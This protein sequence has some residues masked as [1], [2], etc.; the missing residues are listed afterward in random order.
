MKKTL[1]LLFV[2][3]F[4]LAAALSAAALTELPSVRQDASTYFKSPYT[5]MVGVADPFILYDEATATYYLYSTGGH[6]LCYRSQTL[7]VWE[8]LDD[9][10]AVTDKTFGTEKYW[11]PEVYK[12]GDAFYM[13]YSAARDVGGVTRHSIGVATSQSPA[14]PFTDLYDHPLYDPGYNVIDASLLFD[15][16][17]IY[18]YYSRDCSENLIDGKKVS[19]VC[20]IEVKSDLS[21]IVGEPAVLTTP[22]EPWETKTGSTL[23]NEGPCVLK[24][25][26]VYYLM[27]SANYFGSASY[28]V[29]YATASSPL[30]PYKKA[31]ENPILEGDGKATAGTGH[32]NYFRSPDGSELYLVYHSRANIAEP[33]KGSRMLCIDRLVITGDGRLRI[34]GPSSSMQPIPSGVNGLYK[35]TDGIS[36]GSTYPD[37]L[38]HVTNLCDDLV[39]YGR[40]DSAS[41]YRFVC[42]DDGAITLRYD[43]PVSLQAIWLYGISYPTLCPQSVYAVADG[44]YRTQTKM[45]S[46]VTAMLPVALLFD[47]MPE[48]TAVREV[49]L[50]FTPQDQNGRYAALSEIITVTRGDASTGGVNGVSLGQARNG[51]A[52]VRTYRGG[53]TDVA[54]G[55]W[56]ADYI[57]AA[58]EYGLV[59]GTTATTFSPGD[60]FTVAAALTAA[61]NIR[62]AYTGVPV[63]APQSGDAWYM[64]YLR[65]CIENGIVADGQFTD[66]DRRITRGEMATVFAKA[67]PAAEYERLRDGAPADVAFGSADYEGIVTLYAA[68][69]VNGDAGSG[70][71]RPTDAISR[72]EACVIFSRLAVRPD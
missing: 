14:G 9:A 60:G 23:W 17:K 51:F 26:G 44:T 32:C 71:Y 69:I 66:F 45:F 39:A 13:V 57:A 52:R 5:G 18:L 49:K 11:A 6:F 42:A 34:N 29:G 3:L 47:G 50:Y 38:G 63:G 53:F 65:Y 30:G 56:Y 59:S 22:T 43:T 58:Y 27:Y 62:I 41:L 4:G 70:N 8:K 25:N 33:T 21:G 35:K 19:Q 54:A 55:A 36:I 24:Q 12:V 1:A 48:G 72:A 7:K 16:D 40:I 64:P 2:L 15:G 20:G 61:A 68:G 46:S 28:C 37:A 10:Y 67:L 31:P